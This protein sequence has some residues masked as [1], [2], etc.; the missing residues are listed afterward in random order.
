MN[1]CYVER[2]TVIRE[3]DDGNLEVVTFVFFP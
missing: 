3:C 1:I 2:E